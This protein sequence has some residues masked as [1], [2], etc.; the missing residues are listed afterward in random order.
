MTTDYWRD[1][2]L[3]LRFWV[4]VSRQSNGCWY[5]TG[6]VVKASGYGRWRPTGQ[7]NKGVH[8]AVYEA[9]VQPLPTAKPGEPGHLTV[10]HDCHNRSKSCK[11]G[12]TCLHRRCVNPAHLRAVPSKTNVMA[13]RAPSVRNAVA[14]RCLRGHEL[15]VD[16]IY[17]DSDGHRACRRCQIDQSRINRRKKAALRPKQPH[18]QSVKT[19]CRYGHP[20][21]G[22]NLIVRGDGTRGCRECSRARVAAHRLRRLAGL[23]SRPL[24]ER[25]HCPEGHPYDEANTYI[26]PKTGHRQ[27]RTCRKANGARRYAA[28]KASA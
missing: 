28:K 1:S 27:C 22:D 6:Y 21:E 5:W 3:P 7:A 15:T 10:D 19:H 23:E 26:A 8:R 9:L 24:A 13:G 12:V 20:Y 2:R 25:T 17:L 14:T 18:Y 11:G 4:N 16:N